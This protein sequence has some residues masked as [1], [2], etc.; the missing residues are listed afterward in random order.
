MDVLICFYQ[1]VQKTI[2]RKVLF[3]FTPVAGWVVMLLIPIRRSQKCCPMTIGFMAYLK[4]RTFHVLNLISIWVDANGEVRR[5]INT[6]NLIGITVYTLMVNWIWPKA[7]FKRRISRVPNG[8]LMR[9]IF[10]FRSLTLHSAH[11]LMQ[12]LNRAVRV[13]ILLSRLDI[14]FYSAFWLIIVKPWCMLLRNSFFCP[15]QCWLH[16][17]AFLRVM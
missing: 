1:S 11:V 4:H 17:N 15:V 7:R 3:M 13:F 5:L 12:L 6:S 8:M 9:K 2:A 16:I 14:K 10:C